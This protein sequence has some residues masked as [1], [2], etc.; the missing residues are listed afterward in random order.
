MLLQLGHF[1]LVSSWKTF[2]SS[3]FKMCQKHIKAIK[4]FI[5]FY[6]GVKRMLKKCTRWRL[7]KIAL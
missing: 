4:R 3:S 7:S 5:L 1:F 2:I 6:W